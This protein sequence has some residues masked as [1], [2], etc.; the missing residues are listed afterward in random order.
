MPSFTSCGSHSHLGARITRRTAL[1]AGAVGLLGLGLPQLAALRALAGQGAPA[2]RAKSVIYIFLSGGVAQHETFDMKPD[3]PQEIRGE[4]RPI[5][6]RTPGLQICEHL[7]ELAKC[8][9]LWSLI[10]S[11]THGSNDH[12]AGH[13]IML[14]GRSDLPAGFDPSKPRP[15]DWPSIAALATA[16]V[17]PQHN[18]PPAIVLPDK[19]QHNTGRILPGQFGGVM[20]RR[21]GTT[22][23]GRTPHP[24]QLCARVEGDLDVPPFPLADTE[25]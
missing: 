14:T 9:H 22:R 19:I 20:G 10:R 17:P 24:R 2:P 6:T 16:L 15:A 11:L 25:E 18:L 7:P 5:A 12:S 23:R 21:A 3:A 1:Q 13:H 4:F 8:S